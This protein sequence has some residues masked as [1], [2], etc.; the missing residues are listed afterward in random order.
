MRAP[1]QCHENNVLK[2]MS[3]KMKGYFEGSAQESLT[4]KF[5]EAPE[6]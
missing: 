4:V 5:I 1:E 2:T 6:V 3:G